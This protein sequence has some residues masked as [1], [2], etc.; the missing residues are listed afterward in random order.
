M[1]PLLT[2]RASVN[3]A[4]IINQNSTIGISDTDSMSSL[5]EPAMNDNVSLGFTDNDG[6]PF[7][8][9]SAYRAKKKRKLKDIS[10]EAINNLLN[11]FQDKWKQ[12]TETEASI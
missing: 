12:D 1:H 6:D 10:S 3:P 11:V 8:P 4:I 9:A 5:L 7:V 2:N